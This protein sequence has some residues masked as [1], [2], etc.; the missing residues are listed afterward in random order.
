MFSFGS[1][2]LMKVDVNHCQQLTYPS[3]VAMKARRLGHSFMTCPMPLHRWQMILELDE[4]ELGEAP[5]VAP[6]QLL[7]LHIRQFTYPERK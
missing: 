6:F 5:G 4:E 3:S 1:K 2:V 7:G